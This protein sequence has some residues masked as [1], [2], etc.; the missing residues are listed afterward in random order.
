M[1]VRDLM[2]TEVITL[3]LYD[4]LAIAEDIMR[5]GR[6]RHLPVLDG[7]RP[8]GLVS[9]R[10][11]FR[12][13]M[14]SVLELEPGSNQQW[15][16][17]VVVHDVMTRDVE[18]IHPDQPMRSAVETMLEKKIGCLPVV[19]DG[20]LVG[21]ISETDCL[22]YLAHLLQTVDLRQELPELTE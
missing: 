16:E 21:L 15:L 10:D 4:H 8:V 9:Q 19:E 13:G 14:S 1:N 18:T 6:V 5:L 22:S 20:A 2:Q 7:D 11:L 3:S 12:A 17:K